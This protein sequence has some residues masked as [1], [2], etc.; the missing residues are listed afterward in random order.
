MSGNK[1][2]R[3]V[4]RKAVR[5][6]EREGVV[7]EMVRLTERGHAEQLCESLDFDGYDVIVGVGGDGTFH[8]CINGMMRRMLDKNKKAIPLALIAAGTGNSFMHE[9]RCYKLK[10][11]IYH[12]LR[13][14]NY[15]IDICRYVNLLMKRT[16]RV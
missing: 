7:V 5:L 8:E 11:A 14:V 10:A 15:P 16:D 3:S 12:I 2:G 6:M 13:G 9:L 1:R 4:A